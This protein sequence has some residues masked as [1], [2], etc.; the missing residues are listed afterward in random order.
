MSQDA[1][2]VSTTEARQ[3][4]RVGI[5]RVLVS[6]LVLAIGAGVSLAAYF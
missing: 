6:S 2:I 4:Q 3:G 1:Q 5:I